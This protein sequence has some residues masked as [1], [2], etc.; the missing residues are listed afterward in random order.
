M[1]G[2][3]RAQR[4]ASMRKFLKDWDEEHPGL[5][6][7]AKKRVKPKP[8]KKKIKKKKVMRDSKGNPVGMPRVGGK[9][10]AKFIENMWK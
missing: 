4:I 8:K 3:T 7:T 9:A 5:K 2:Q 1:G 10:D 6:K